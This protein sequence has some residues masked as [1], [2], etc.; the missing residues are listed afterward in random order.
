MGI[1][2]TATYNM[3]N[4]AGYQRI[5]GTATY[6]MANNAATTQLAFPVLSADGTC[7]RCAEIG[8]G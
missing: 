8:N 7:G 4:N 5:P 3:T 1:P 6:N 2:G